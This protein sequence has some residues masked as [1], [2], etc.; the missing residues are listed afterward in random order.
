MP[1]PLKRAFSAFCQFTPARRAK[2][3]ETG[4]EGGQERD[5]VLRGGCRVQAT[6]SRREQR[7]TFLSGKSVL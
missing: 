5:A 6:F 4:G 1:L 7:G 2:M 3:P